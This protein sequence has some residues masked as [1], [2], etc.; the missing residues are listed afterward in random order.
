MVENK[1]KGKQAEQIVANLLTKHLFP[2]YIYLNPSHQQIKQGKEICDVLILF[3][4]QAIVIQI[5]DIKIKHDLLKADYKQSS[6]DL[7]RDLQ[8]ELTEN[9]KFKKNIDQASG[10][11]RT[12]LN[13][14][15]KISLFNQAGIEDKIDLGQINKVHRV[16]CFNC[17]ML[18]QEILHHGEDNPVHI[19]STKSFFEISKRIYSTSDLINYLSDRDDLLQTIKSKNIPLKGLEK[20]FRC[21][22]AGAEDDLF[23][24]WDR[25][26]SFRKNSNLEKCFKGAKCFFDIQGLNKHSLVDKQFQDQHKEDEEMLQLW[27]DTTMGSLEDST[28]EPQYK[29]I[30]DELVGLPFYEQVYLGSAIHLLNQKF[31]TIDTTRKFFL[32]YVLMPHDQLGKPTKVYL[33]IMS[34]ASLKNV[35]KK[36]L[37]C[38]L[39]MMIASKITRKL[40]SLKHILSIIISITEDSRVLIVEG[41]MY[42]KVDESLLDKIESNKP[43]K[44]LAE[45]NPMIRKYDLFLKNELCDMIRIDPFYREVKKYLNLQNW[46]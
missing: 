10:A 21:N 42:L 34:S 14:R 22:L 25:C 4:N 45:N 36:P 38:L 11:A 30:S 15:E 26:R 46:G 6:K 16:A 23:S 40:P 24:L 28:R 12:L 2:H 7:I 20:S 3:K 13:S 33:I 37:G 5:K 41:F 17:D 39:N 8:G 44:G 27:Q 31:L 32:R 43:L 1:N 18:S 35:P 9:K 19:I 29:I